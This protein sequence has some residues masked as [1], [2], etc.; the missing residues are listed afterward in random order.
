MISVSC[1]HCLDTPC[2]CRRGTDAMQSMNSTIREAHTLPPAE[3]PGRPRDEGLRTRILH[4]TNTLRQEKG[5]GQMTIEGVAKRAECGKATIYRWWDGKPQL[6]S[7]AL[8]WSMT[9]DEVRTVKVLVAGLL[10]RG[11]AVAQ[12]VGLLLT[13]P[14]LRKGFGRGEGKGC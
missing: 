14:E 9:L 13:H 6:V 8:E 10:V 3:G 5:Y 2:T 1:P 11:P 12:A 7:E 4:A